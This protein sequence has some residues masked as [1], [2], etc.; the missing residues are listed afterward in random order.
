MEATSLAFLIQNVPCILD[1]DACEVVVGAVLSQKIYGSERPIAFFLHVMSDTQKKYCTT[2]RK[3]LAVVC[4]VQ[5]FRHYLYGTKVIL[6][7]PTDH[8]S[9]E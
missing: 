8:Y 5:H 4:A 1:T 7:R 6:H 2:R 3:L 9:M